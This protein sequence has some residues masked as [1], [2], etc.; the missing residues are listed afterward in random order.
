MRITIDLRANRK[1]KRAS[2]AYGVLSSQSATAR[3]FGID[4]Q[5]CT[6]QQRR[7]RCE[8]LTSSVNIAVFNIGNAISASVGG[9]ALSAFGIA[10]ITWVEVA[11]PLAAIGIA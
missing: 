11:F 1:S 8:T 4:E 7:C 9:I 5:T 6:S 10:A 2:S 3:E